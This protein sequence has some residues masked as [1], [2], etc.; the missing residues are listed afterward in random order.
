MHNIHN[1]QNQKSAADT[2]VFVGF[3]GIYQYVHV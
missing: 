3:P 2:I 1:S